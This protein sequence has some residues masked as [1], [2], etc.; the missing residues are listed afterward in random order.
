MTSSSTPPGYLDRF[1]PGVTPYKKILF[2][3][4]RP[5]QAAELTEIQSI[6][7]YEHQQLASSVYREGAAISGMAPYT[8]LE[9]QY[10]VTFNP[11]NGYSPGDHV[12]DGSGHGFVCIQP[13][14]PGSSLLDVHSWAPSHGYV[15]ILGGKI[16]AQ[17]Y[18]HSIDASPNFELTA[19]G[20]ERIG[21]RIT[22]EVTTMADD[23]GL[24]DPA[25]GYENYECEGA[26]RLSF[27]Y[28]YTY[29]DDSAVTVLEIISGQ[30]NQQYT[31]IRAV[32]DSVLKVL[33][34]RTYD[35][36]GSYMVD[37]YNISV[38]DFSANDYQYP[39][40]NRVLVRDGSAY[41]NGW[42]SRN[43]VAYLRLRRP[44]DLQSV[45]DE[46]IQ[47][48]AA[49][50]YSTS[51]N[52]I[53]TI[54]SLF[55]TA[56]S[57]AISITRGAIANGADSVP[58]IYQPVQSI[59]SVAGYTQ[60][61]DYVRSGNTISWSPLGSEPPVGSTYSVV[62]QYTQQLSKSIRSPTTLTAQPVVRGS[63]SGSG[64]FDYITPVVSSAP[65]L[66]YSEILQVIAVTQGATT[67]VENIDFSLEKHS[68]KLVWISAG[69]TSGSTYEITFTYWN[70]TTYGYYIARDSYQT[71][72]GAV[73]YSNTPTY[74]PTGDLIDYTKQIYILVS[75][76]ALNIVVGSY[77]Y[78]GYG[79]SLPRVDSV[80]LDEDGVLTLV[81]GVPATNPAP[82]PYDNTKLR[83][84]TIQ[85]PPEGAGKFNV[86]MDDS[87]RLTMIDLRKMLHMVK[88]TQYN[89]AV[90]QL[91][92]SAI[93]ENLPTDK[94]AIWAESF[95][96]PSLGN[97]TDPDFAITYDFIHKRA[98][99]PQ[100]G[101]KHSPNPLPES[102]TVDKGL[103]VM[104][105][106]TEITFI[107][108]PYN[109]GSIQINAYTRVN[110]S[111][112]ISLTPNVDRWMDYNTVNITVNGQTYNLTE[113]SYANSTQ[114]TTDASLVGTSTTSSG[115]YTS[116]EHRRSTDTN[117]YYTLERYARQ[118]PVEINGEGF[119]AEEDNI[120]VIF[121]GVQVNP[122]ILA[123]SVPGTNNWTL[124]AD[125][126]GNIGCRFTIPPNQP[127]GNNI[128]DVVGASLYSAGSRASA[129]IS[130]QGTLQTTVKTTT[131]TTYVITT[132]YVVDT[133][134]I[135]SQPAPT[136]APQICGCPPPCDPIA[137]T[138]SAPYAT[139]I[140]S[141]DLF[142]TQKPSTG[143]LK[144]NFV[145]VQIR[146]VVDGLPGKTILGASTRLYPSTVN[147]NTAG[148]A[149]TT[150]MLEAPVYV[151][152]N[153]EYCFVVLCDSEM[154]SIAIARVGDRDP[155]FG[156]VNSN[157]NSGVLL[158]SANA[159]TWSPEQNADI[160][161]LLR[162][163]KF[164]EN[165][166]VDYGTMSF[167]QARSR[168]EYSVTSGVPNS[169][170][171]IMYEYSLDGSRWLPMP[172]G[173]EINIR[174]MVNSVHLRATLVVSANKLVAPVLYKD[175][176]FIAYNWVMSGAYVNRTV[177]VGT[178]AARYIHV[179]FNAYIPTGTCT[180]TPKVKVD[181][182]PYINMSIVPADTIVYGDGYAEYHYSYDHTAGFTDSQIKVDMT[183]S[184]QAIT[185]VI[186]GLREVVSAL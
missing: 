176:R 53:R 1:I 135:E 4:G 84:C 114:S 107:N 58:S 62:V 147:V 56:Q 110:L 35:E 70:V 31:Q 125:A 57:P 8:V 89:L 136:P 30:V 2:V 102:T 93:N 139:Y 152:R 137:Q 51:D 66:T 130:S 118:I 160:K 33:S 9:A 169:M 82:V 132:Q 172:N 153:T 185:P 52:P 15:Q 143:N 75:S 63:L 145:S 92:Q 39:M 178:S 186:Y 19:L 94:K 3:P 173:L 90:F 142:F 166:V 157:P 97:L 171:N 116:V 80:Y 43:N 20:V 65:T 108:Q 77:M 100:Q 180:V 182:G 87:Q 119:I 126:D 167:T 133:T 25:I 49:K 13:V 104:P 73:D 64:T 140:T 14:G 158:T 168:F 175:A 149:A 174:Q 67:Y 96:D 150:F 164:T 83:L 32:Q 162:S 22:S 86:I 148:T 161:F 95:S 34:T 60:G 117:I 128:V 181:G 50:I 42:N 61:V 101:E 69:P 44:V 18:I 103:F 85:S 37:P 28:A 120:F 146:N 127:A 16:Y 74:T 111:A 5:I 21:I 68:G 183:T 141:I 71:T 46:A 124:K 155:I 105:P 78:I 79:F 151:D 156:Y 138:F 129:L 123:P 41:V 55:V 38:G 11:A 99:L 76:S 184:D 47:F 7:G 159:I 72:T 134:Y 163:T 131:I 98:Y 165:A 154:Y 27:S 115:S 106:Y 121:N 12:N 17:G 179:W 112:F 36:A 48:D 109:T 10:P 23:L 26:D 40:Y 81:E 59:V 122:E 45:Y 177:Q 88:D 54:S 113:Y 24:S 144:S 170:C 29:N 6:L 91:Y